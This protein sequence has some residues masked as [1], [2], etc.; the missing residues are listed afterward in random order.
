MSIMI[1][2]PKQI[3]HKSRHLAVRQIRPNWYKVSSPA[4]KLEYDVNLGLN[5]GTCSCTWG[6]NRPAQD[7]RS[8]CSHVI[9]AM[10]YRAVKLGKRLSVWNNK[11]AAQRQH[12][13]IT[14]IGDGVF[15]TT[16]RIKA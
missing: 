6:R 2:H 1:A 7:H 13:P 16:R 9:A 8:G 11:A 14:Q 5:G 3:Q 15:V 10:N 12:R 4:S